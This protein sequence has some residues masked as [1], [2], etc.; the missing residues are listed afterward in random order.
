MNFPASQRALKTVLKIENILGPNR[1][2]TS[3]VPA[4]VGEVEETA[5]PPA[6]PGSVLPRL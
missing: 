3:D 2:T 1:C 6:R 5:R 4:T